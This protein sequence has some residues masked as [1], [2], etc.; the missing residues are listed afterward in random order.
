[1]ASRLKEVAEGY[2]E[3]AETLATRWCAHAEKTAA[4]VEA[5]DYGVEAAR[6]D[7]AACA[8]LV[9]ESWF[10]VASEAVDAIAI[11]T[12]TQH[13]PYV[14]DS[15]AFV[16]PLPGAALSLD[17]PL[18]AS[19][20]QDAVPVDRVTILPAEL[21][22]GKQQFRL[23]VDAGGR[24]ADTY[25]GKVTATAPGAAPESIDVLIQIA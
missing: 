20:R 9:T 16:S 12:G 11:L 13:R 23:R 14:L 21:K 2:A 1:V 22:P 18:S 5:G 4:G 7:L 17:G 15:R 24:K 8:F 3:L 6:R 25:T 19:V 10:L